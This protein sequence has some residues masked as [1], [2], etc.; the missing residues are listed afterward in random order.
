MSAQPELISVTPG[1]PSAEFPDNPLGWL[2]QKATKDK[3]KYFLAH[4]NDGVN[5]GRWDGKHWVLSHDAFPKN[6][7]EFAAERLQSVRLFGDDVE[8]LLWQEGA[9][10]KGRILRD[11]SY[12][13]WIDE[14]QLLWGSV[15]EGE[16]EG[17]LLLAEGAEGLRHAV[18]ALKGEFIPAKK[19]YCIKVRN[20]LNFDEMGQAWVAASR[21]RGLA[22]VKRGVK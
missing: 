19:R 13:E 9:V 8:L 3:Y 2:G 21:I 15:V 4:S 1:N 18:P 6:A 14:R 11:S 20:Y 12:D 7:P 16:S 17:F 10:W 22:T 5:W